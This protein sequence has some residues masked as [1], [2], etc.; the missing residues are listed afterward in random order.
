[1]KLVAL[2]VTAISCLA[3]AADIIDGQ[4]C[5]RLCMVSYINYLRYH[6]SEKAMEKC[7]EIAELY[8]L[9]NFCSKAV[10]V[11]LKIPEMDMKHKNPV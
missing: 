10:P 1:M 5:T 8:R 3:Y 4:H 7:N 2:L 9:R 6:D 11:M